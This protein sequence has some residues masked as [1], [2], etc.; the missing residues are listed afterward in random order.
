MLVSEP[1]DMSLQA[2]NLIVGMYL[3]PIEGVYNIG[4]L[5]YGKSL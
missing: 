4:I 3:Q 5:Q 1:K 2:L